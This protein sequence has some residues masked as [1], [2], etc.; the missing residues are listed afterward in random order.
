M[1]CAS[2]PSSSKPPPTAT[3]GRS[4]TSA[5]WPTCSASRARW[6]RRSRARSRSSSRS[7]SAHE[8]YLKGRHLWNQRTSEALEGALELFRRAIARDPTYAPAF[9][10]LA[11]CHNLLA[12]QNEHLPVVAFPLAREAAVRAL[13]LDPHLAEAHTSLGFVKVEGDWDWTG[14]EREY[15]QA[16]ELDQGYAT[17]HQ[18]YAIL[19]VA[20]GRT[21]EGIEHALEAVRCDPLSFI[22]DS[23]AGDAFYYARRYD[24]ALEAYRRGIELAPEFGQLRMDLAR[25][26]ELS[27]RL[28]EAIEQ[29]RRAITMMRGDPARSPGLACAHAAAGRDDEAR[30][31][32]EAMRVHA[33]A[34]YVPPYAFASVHARLGEI[35]AAFE[36]LERAFRERDRAMV[37]VRVNPRF[38]PLRADRRFDDLVRRM[39]LDGPS[40]RR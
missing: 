14:G 1:A 28:D 37:Y 16:I 21:Q 40:S 25:T 17:A 2:R 31:I 27:G 36:A 12:D 22:L 26:L 30:A 8:D 35:D 9:S 10:G 13:E 3:C 38:D 7:R 34:S 15:L 20:L 11:D 18:W 32:L 39:R 5:T 33:R 23:T 29:Y 24:E 4:A 19:L 6:R